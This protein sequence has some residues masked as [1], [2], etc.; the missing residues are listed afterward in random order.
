[1]WKELCFHLHSHRAVPTFGL[2]FLD[3]LESCTPVAYPFSALETEGIRGLKSQ[4]MEMLIWQ[5]LVG[6]S[7]KYN[8]NVSGKK[9]SPLLEKDL[10]GFRA[11]ESLSGAEKQSQEDFWDLS[12]REFPAPHRVGNCHG[13]GSWPWTYPRI[14]ICPNDKITV[15]KSFRH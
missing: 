12:N 3:L 1:M 4:K 2:P 14:C 11:N 15:L 13:Q 7:A 9:C 6:N 8:S 5:M 10:T